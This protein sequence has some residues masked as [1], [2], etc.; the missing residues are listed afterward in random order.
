MAAMLNDL[1][2]SSDD[3]TD[4]RPGITLTTNGGGDAGSS[5]D[6]EGFV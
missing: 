6:E 2:S 1:H 5:G 4:H 3:E